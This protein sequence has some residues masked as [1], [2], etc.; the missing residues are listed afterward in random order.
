MHQESVVEQDQ[1]VG[2]IPQKQDMQIIFLRDFIQSDDYVANVGNV[3][4]F[5]FVGELDPFSIG[6]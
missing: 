3:F 5:H 4:G 2:F 1:L 6:A